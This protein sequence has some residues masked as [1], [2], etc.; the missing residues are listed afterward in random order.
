MNERLEPQT[1]TQPHLHTLALTELLRFIRKESTSTMSQR[2]A[3][4][5]L[6]PTTLDC[7]ARRA[8][9]PGIVMRFGDI[10][11]PLLYMDTFTSSGSDQ[12][13]QQGARGIFVKGII[14]TQLGGK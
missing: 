7:V 12:N 1:S 2:G 9:Y 6:L 11:Y 10:R 5:T 14:W 4:R 8:R 3:I 13:A